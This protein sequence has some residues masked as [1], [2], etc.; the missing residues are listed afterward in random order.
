MAA[1]GFWRLTKESFCARPPAKS[2]ICTAVRLFQLIGRSEKTR[3]GKA[4]ASRR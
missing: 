2:A 1:A 3:I 4:R